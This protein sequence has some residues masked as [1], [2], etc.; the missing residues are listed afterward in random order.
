MLPRGQGITV[1][2]GE[3]GDGVGEDPTTMTTVTDGG[4]TQGASR[5]NDPSIQ[6]LQF[7]Y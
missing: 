5:T 7:P 3:R 6:C 1:G 4:E 2:T